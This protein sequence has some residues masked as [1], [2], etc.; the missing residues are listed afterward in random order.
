MKLNH[1]KYLFLILTFC[2][3]NLCSISFAK[4]SSNLTETLSG[5]VIGIAD[6]DTLTILIDGNSQVKVRLAGIDAPEKTQAFGNASKKLLSNK[7]FSQNIKV[8]ARGK[9]KYGRVLGIIRLGD[10][11]INE[12]MIAEGLAW[13]YKKYAKD[14]PA[15]EADQYSRTEEIARLNKKGLW[16]QENPTPPWDYR[17]EKKKSNH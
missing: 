1:L 17:A 6:G 13:H 16:V 10:Q 2:F 4:D 9:D 5:K 3:T 14:Q 8:E 12:Y 11:D 15:G 7:V